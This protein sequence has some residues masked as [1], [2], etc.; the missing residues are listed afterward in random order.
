M[1]ERLLEHLHSRANSR[2][3]VLANEDALLEK[4]ATT[5]DALTRALKI[6]EAQRTV[7]VL[8]PLPFVVIK[9]M[10]WSGSNAPRVRKE[11]QI[12]DSKRSLHIEVP[13]SSAAAA[14]TQEV[15][16][17]G[18]GEALLD[19]VLAALGP[20]ADRAEFRA[21]L[22][23]NDPAL[24]HRCLRRVRATKAI[25]VSRAALFRSLLQRLSH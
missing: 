23:G 2:G 3:L 5:H 7:E 20:G 13:V 11:Q 12:S 22:A 4:L 1:T 15:G 10:K 25:R 8:A 16:G 6:L 19:Q 18:E 17:L 24:I 9:L 14:A 21:I